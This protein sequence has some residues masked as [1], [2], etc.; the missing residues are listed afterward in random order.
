V[1]IAWTTI[2]TIA[3]LL[4]GLF[5]FIGLSF[6]D[7]LSR[8]VVRS[9]VVSEVGLAIVVALF[10]HSISLLVLSWFGFRLSTF[11]LP[12]MQYGTIDDPAYVRYVVGRLPGS[13][14]YLLVTAG[15]GFGAG[16]I[17]SLLIVLGPLRFLATHKWLYDVLASDRKGGVVTAYVMTA[18]VE[19]NKALMYKGRLHEF[20]LS[21]DGKISYVVLKDCT[22]YFLNFAGE[23]P[24]T[25]AQMNLFGTDQ[26]TRPITSWD[27]LLIEGSQIANVL[28]DP[29]YDWI[30]ATDEGT[31]A[32]DRA[33]EEALA[34]S[35]GRG[36]SADLSPRS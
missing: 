17:V 35:L 24:E 14:I 6:Y 31:E 12:F 7:R 5:F 36:H 16:Y 29:S 20:F 25:T 3:L 26:G 9:G 19:N 30:R 28:F 27:Y 11:I 10:L 13:L 1:S 2:L 4:P 33:V 8:E 34:R 23:S 22:K 32:L 15:L 21:Q 18:S